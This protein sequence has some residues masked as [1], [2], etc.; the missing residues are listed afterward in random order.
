MK[1]YT[2]QWIAAC[3]LCLGLS[4]SAYGQ[5]ATYTAEQC[6][7][8][9][10]KNNTLIKNAKNNV[11]GAEQTRKEAFT[12]YFPSISATGM[13]FNADKGVAKLAIAEGMEF[14]LMKNGIVAGVT[15]VQPVFAGGQIVNGNK[16]AKVG[17]EVSR[18]QLEQSE[19]EVELT[20]EQYFW[21]VVSLQEKMNTVCAVDTMLQ[22]LCKD[23]NAAVSA[24]VT[25]RNDL[26]Q[27]QLKQNEIASTRINLD[28]GI[29]VC[30]MLLAQYIGADNTG[31]SLVA[32]IPE[33]A[34]PASPE[35]L[36]RNPA[37]SLGLTPEYRLLQKNVEANKL[38]QRM[39]VGKNLPTVG[40]GVGYMYHDLLDNDRSF[41]M[42][43]ASVSVPLSG[44]WGGSHAIKKQKMQV[45]NAENDLTD[46]SELLIIRMQKAW[47]DVEDAYKQLGIAR[48]SI[49]QSTE[50][51]R[52]NNEY[53]RAGT[54]TMS[55]LLNAQ[56]LYQQSRDGYVD[57][58][59]TYQL[60]KLEYLQATGR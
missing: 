3:A 42:V 29:A 43:F 36:Y 27:V 12:N 24:G 8:M 15:A 21:Q 59:A 51:L 16:L 13:G 50:N 40:V 41:G 52:L 9:A 35:E 33:E 44:W 58:Y 4:L 11:T 22:R 47:N 45:R 32:D 7:E 54:T 30:K 20:A 23:V 31:F 17:V 37:T 26:L 38:Q 34:L 18:L 25:T 2:P 28:N 56:T 1:Q 39:A 55:D 46:K 19:N 57:A 6:R 48:K 60:K 53:Y 14:S 10:L 49:E 5:D